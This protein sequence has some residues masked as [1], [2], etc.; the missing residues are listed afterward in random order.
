MGMSKYVCFYL[1]VILLITQ[2]PEAMA[3][4]YNPSAAYFL[5]MPYSIYNPYP[6]NPVHQAS[7]MGGIAGNLI[8]ADCGRGRN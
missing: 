1:C 6:Y 2:S 4:I 8:C 3:Q 5:A 7:V